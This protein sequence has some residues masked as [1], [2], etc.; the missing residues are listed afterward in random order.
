MFEYY[1]LSSAIAFKFDDKTLANEWH[2]FKYDNT[3]A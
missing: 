3:A 2:N 1:E